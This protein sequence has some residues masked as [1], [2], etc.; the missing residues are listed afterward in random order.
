M[1]KFLAFAFICSMMPASA[2]DLPT[3]PMNELSPMHDMQS[4]Q[5]QRFRMENI[6]YYNDVETEKARY[7]KRTAQPT[8][9]LQEKINQAVEKAN[10]INSKSEFVRE[11]GKLKIKYGN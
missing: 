2:F 11:N 10:K 4:M 3:V 1:K 7:K 8:E 9:E 5:A 6:D